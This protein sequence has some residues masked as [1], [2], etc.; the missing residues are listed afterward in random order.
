MLWVMMTM[1]RR[2][3]KLD[4]TVK[5]WNKEKERQA[6]NVEE[7]DRTL[8][9][10]EDE[11]IMHG[12]KSSCRKWFLGVIIILTVFA[13]GC[14]QDSKN[15]KTLTI[16]E[17]FNVGNGIEIKAQSVDNG[18]IPGQTDTTPKQ[19]FLSIVKD[20]DILDNV[21]LENGESYNYGNI[22]EFKIGD[23]YSGDVSDSVTLKN[24]IYRQ[25][26]D[27]PLKTGKKLI[28]TGETIDLGKG[29][30]MAVVQIYRESPRKVLLILSKSGVEKDKKVVMP[31]E[32]YNYDNYIIINIGRIFSGP[33]LDAIV[34][35]KINV[36]TDMPTDQWYT[37]MKWATKDCTLCQKW[38]V[39]QFTID[40]MPNKIV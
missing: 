10:N 31:G 40:N 12:A 27:V 15:E 3:L 4:K 34:I 8:H 18:V 37:I 7:T 23:I 39:L 21:I 11:R 24:I 19:V 22:L 9:K 17:T 26:G 14:V 20:G 32:V 38:A 6:M 35:D 29:F 28:T 30:S 36:A 5:D 33:V 25:Y 1:L 2:W 16:G 13:L